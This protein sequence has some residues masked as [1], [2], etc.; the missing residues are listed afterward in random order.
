MPRNLVETLLGAVVLTVAIGFLAYAY[1]NSN[2]GDPGGYQ[3]IAKFDRVDGLDV[4]ADVRIS[5]IKVGRV[6]AQRLDPV[7]FRAEVRFSVA[8]G[9]EV[10]ADS[11]ASIVSTSLLGGKYL[12][13]QPGA[14][15][16]MLADGGE[17]TLTQSAINLEDMIGQFVFGGTGGG[18]Q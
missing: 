9:I 3:L 5:G 2:V 15:D 4:G 16:V 17:I 13:V 8:Q 18:G 6:L 7:T 1:T 11:S 14:E 10:P 12:A